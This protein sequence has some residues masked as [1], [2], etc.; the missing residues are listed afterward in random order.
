MEL[1]NTNMIVHLTLT[2]IKDSR[3]DTV[4]IPIEFRALRMQ[5][6]GKSYKD[7]LNKANT[8]IESV[9]SPRPTREIVKSAKKGDRQMIITWSVDT[10]VV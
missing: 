6:E 10:I 5:T 8:F 9:I 2:S 7:C 3:G 1:H 4:E